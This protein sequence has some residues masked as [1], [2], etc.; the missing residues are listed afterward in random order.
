MKVG[1]DD[2]STYNEMMNCIF[3][4][5]PPNIVIDSLVLSPSE[6][7]LLQQASYLTSGIYNQP[8]VASTSTLLQ[9]M[10]MLY[11]PSVKARETLA[12]P[13]QNVVDFKAC[14]FCCNKKVDMAYICSVCLSIFCKFSETCPTCGTKAK[15]KG[16]AKSKKSPV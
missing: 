2:P 8:C 16:K 15:P 3:A 6:S 14:C 7:T 5:K 4:A 13:Q 11:L 10:L 9:Y 1:K 12:L